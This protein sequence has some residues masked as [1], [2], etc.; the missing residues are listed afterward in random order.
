[1]F[2]SLECVT[3][4]P[5]TLGSYIYCNDQPCLFLRLVGGSGKSE[6]KLIHPLLDWS[7]GLGSSRS[8]QSR[9]INTF[10]FSLILLVRK[11]DWCACFPHWV[12]LIFTVV[13][14][15]RLNSSNRANRKLELAA[16]PP[17]QWNPLQGQGIFI[18]IR[19]L[20]QYLIIIILG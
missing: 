13:C 7:W 9:Q 1:M 20:K 3:T 5:C 8:Y 15:R 2:Q 17:S 4:F 14:G 12:V 6:L 18:F 10:Y 11:R 16:T 19:F